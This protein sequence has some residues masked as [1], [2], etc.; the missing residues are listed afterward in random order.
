MAAIETAEVLELSN[1]KLSRA[2]SSAR[3]LGLAFVTQISI[4][5]KMGDVESLESKIRTCLSELQE[6]QLIPEDK[7]RKETL[8]F[9]TGWLLFAAMKRGQRLT[10]GSSLEMSLTRL[11]EDANM[12]GMAK[13][14]AQLPTGKVA[15]VQLFEK[16]L[17]LPMVA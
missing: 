14:L 1:S 4:Y 15:S 7:L 17:H 11:A 6:S 2:K 8:Y 9:V 3:N 13:E 10:K 16:R 5:V 12:S